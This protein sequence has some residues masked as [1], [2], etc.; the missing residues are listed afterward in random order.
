MTA[1]DLVGGEGGDEAWPRVPRRSFRR[2]HDAVEGLG[3]DYSL[4]QRAVVL[5]TG[6]NHTCLT[7]RMRRDG[8]FRT[9]EIIYRDGRFHHATAFSGPIHGMR[10]GPPEQIERLRTLRDALAAVSE[11]VG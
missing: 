4:G 9:V 3:V 1:E 11:G 10:S 5:D 7:V 8:K 2:V 6:K